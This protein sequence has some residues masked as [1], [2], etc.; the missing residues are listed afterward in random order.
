MREWM[1]KAREAQ[2]LTQTDL[3]KKIGVSPQAI[4]AIEKGN[5][6]PRPATATKIALYLNVD[7]AWFYADNTA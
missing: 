5:S 1:R 4:S 6:F 3:A 7:V 2:H